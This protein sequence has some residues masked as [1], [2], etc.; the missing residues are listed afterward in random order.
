MYVKSFNTISSTQFNY[1]RNGS[2]LTYQPLI[3]SNQFLLGLISL[4]IFM[5]ILH[6]LLNPSSFLIS[7]MPVLV[8]PAQF[9]TS[10]RLKIT[11]PPQHTHSK[12]L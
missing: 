12:N 4:D 11:T 7:S 8:T 5:I 1:S 2:F 10:S 6:F 3:G 9:Q